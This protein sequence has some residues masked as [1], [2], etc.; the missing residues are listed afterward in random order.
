[1]NNDS[2]DGALKNRNVDGDGQM[3]ESLSVEACSPV[4]KIF[5]FSYFAFTYIRCFQ[6]ISSITNIKYFYKTT[7]HDFD[8]GRKLSEKWTIVIGELTYRRIVS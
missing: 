4:T 7:S 6:V 1:M 8:F 3:D 5:P 2:D